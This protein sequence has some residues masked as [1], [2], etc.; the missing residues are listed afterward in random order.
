MKPEKLSLELLHKIY[1]E[2]KEEIE[3]KLQEFKKVL[4]KPDESI[5]EELVYCILTAKSSARAADRAIKSLKE[6]CLLLHGS[7]EEV[8][9]LLVG[10]L[11]AKVKAK[12]IVKARTFFSTRNGIAIKSRLPADPHEARAFLADNVE[13]IGYKEASHFLRNIGY[14]GLAILDRH[15]LRGLHELGVIGDMPKS[16]TK[17]RYLEIEKAYLN[18]AR[19]IGIKPEALD[20]VLWSAKTGEVLK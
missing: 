15:V 2:R 18:F 19:K 1:D 17:R 6:K 4:A 8:E 3:G 16:I 13:G 12:R 7:A 20:L 10:V 5:F 11:Y 14:D 9:Q